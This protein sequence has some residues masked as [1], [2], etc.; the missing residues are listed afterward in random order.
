MIAT[1]WIANPQAETIT[2][3]WLQGDAYGEHG[4]F[5]RGSAATSVLLPGFEIAVDTVFDV[6]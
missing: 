2:V 3:L 1:N 5:G 4:I 6:D